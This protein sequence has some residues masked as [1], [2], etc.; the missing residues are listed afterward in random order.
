M[1]KDTITKE[2]PQGDAS[3]EKIL[4]TFFCIIS[5]RIFLD[6]YAYTFMSGYVFSWEHA[7]HSLLYFSSLFLSFSIL[8]FFLTKEDF[9]KILSFLSK[10]STVILIVPLVDL[11]INRAPTHSL[12]LSMGSSNFIQTFLQLLNPFN[13][14][15]IT[16]GIYFSAYLTLILFFIFVYKKTH[17]INNSLAAIFL[18]FLIFSMYSI[19]PSIAFL[20]DF[21]FSSGN[22][23]DLLYL[24]TLKQS[25]LGKDFL[26]NNGSLDSVSSNMNVLYEFAMARL[27]WLLIIIQSAVILFLSNRIIWGSFVKNSRVERVA[28]YSLIATIGIILTSR[29]SG[30]INIYNRINLLT[31]ISFFFLIALNAWVAAFINDKE[32]VE[33]DAISNPER[34]F[35]DKT[36]PKVEW[37]SLNKYLF[38]LMILGFLLLDKTVSFLLILT[39]CAFYIYSVPPLKLK[40]HFLSSSILIGATTVFM[41]MSGFFLVSSHQLLLGFPI[42]AL[43]IIGLSYALL[44]N[45]KDIKDY[46]GD[47][48]KNIR[49]MPVVF[50]LE[51]SKK[52][53]ALLYV[54]VFMNIPFLLSL[55][56]LLPFAII[57]SAIVLY[58][59][60]KKIYQEKYIFYTKF[61]YM[62][63]LYFLTR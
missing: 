6:S 61:V 47:K 10:V 50:G 37:T 23:P 63:I 29:L 22:Q 16:K 41:A 32:D 49:T 21:G 18:G 26:L 45:I 27:Y 35:V 2:N 57:A 1:I 53:I 40:R 44:S 15:G 8:L 54:L 36:T 42:K 12:Y 58:L 51:K 9:K 11:L 52:I 28:N 33:I 13:D 34:P 30:N 60:T 17:N 24:F 43:L 5:L 38:I 14:L 39:Q 20:P 62:V 31:I 19:L 7:L 3:L 46:A 55:K 25:W 4:T 56:S 48:A 59:L